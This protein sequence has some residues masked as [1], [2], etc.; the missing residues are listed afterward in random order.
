[1]FA[2]LHAEK[3]PEELRNKFEFANHLSFCLAGLLASGLFI[4]GENFIELWI[5]QYDEISILIIILP[6]IL[7]VGISQ[8]PTIMILYAINKHK[9]YAYQN[10]IESVFN[11]I[12]SLIF[13]QYW[14]IYGVAIGT[15]LPMIIGRIL[16]LPRYSCKQLDYS[17]TKYYK[18]YA[19]SLLL[20]VL[21]PLIANLTFTPN[22]SWLGILIA[23]LAFSIIY[24]IIFFSLVAEVKTKDHMIK[25]L[26][27]ALFA[28]RGKKVR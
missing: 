4:F 20:S 14:G 15:V 26:N 5:N 16:F 18:I 21:M 17:L 13:L 6:V 25:L 19:K 11:I 23:S 22:F 2:K 7:L 24:V 3:K 28:T 27:K 1:M 8:Q 12:L 9:Y 10:I